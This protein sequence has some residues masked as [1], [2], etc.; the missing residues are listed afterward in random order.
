M[1][2]GALG[3]VQCGLV[4]PG[5]DH[6]DGFALLHLLALGELDWLQ[7]AADPRLHR[8]AHVGRH[9]TQRGQKDGHR[10]LF[11]GRHLHRNRLVPQR[12]CLAGV[13]RRALH[14]ALVDAPDDENQRAHQHKVNEDAH[15]V[16]L[17]GGRLL[18]CVE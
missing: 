3:L 11:R 6:H 5:V 8:H 12:G 9:R 15:P 17:A 1:G 16:T 13:A 2:Q 10:L 4:G 18:R 7:L 14:L